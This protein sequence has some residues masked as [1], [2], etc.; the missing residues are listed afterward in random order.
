MCTG[1]TEMDRLASWRATNTTHT[2]TCSHDFIGHVALLGWNEI[3][4]KPYYPD[5]LGRLFSYYLNDYRLPTD[6]T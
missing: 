1:L 4:K 2:Y 6:F 5:I 3:L